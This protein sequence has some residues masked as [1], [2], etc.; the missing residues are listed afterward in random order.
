MATIKV[1]TSSNLNLDKF[2]EIFAKSPMNAR[3]YSLS[4]QVVKNELLLIET[5]EHKFGIIEQTEKYGVSKTDKI[6]SRK[7]AT[8][9]YWINNGK[10]Y[11]QDNTNRK[12][13]LRQINYLELIGNK[14]VEK[15]LVE[16]YSWIKFL[17]ENHLPIVFNSI[18]RY[19]LFD[20]RK[21]LTH[22]YK[23]PYPVV[24]EVHA[25][26]KTQGLSRKYWIELLKYC[27]NT[28]N[29]NVE[30]MN[31]LQLLKDATEMARKL[32]TTVNASWSVKRLKQEHDDWSKTITNILFTESNRELKISPVFIE[33]DKQIGGLLRT[34]KD[35]ALEGM[36][37]KHCVAGYGNKVDYGNC[38]IFHY[39]GYTA[40]VNKDYSSDVLKLVQFRGYTNFSA[41]TELHEE[42]TTIIN[43]F[44]QT[45][46]EKENKE[47]YQEA[48][49][50][51]A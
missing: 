24:K 35:L 34:T 26:F 50:R 7:S 49:Y 39:K 19:K 47:D 48:C 15:I 1:L 25:K 13:D 2:R 9:K 12:T 3:I 30:L 10:F 33:L 40:E 45:K 31:N 5:S 6:Y 11:V 16:K 18:T 17:Q 37:Q 20:L 4:E 32:N 29:F 22:Y 42:L 23:I 51:Y 14:E 36:K 44:N 21:V 28:T 46:N 43:N 41:P 27:T 38:A 8:K